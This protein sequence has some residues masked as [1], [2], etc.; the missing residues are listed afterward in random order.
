MVGFVL[1]RGMLGALIGVIIGHWMDR[2]WFGAG[3]A[4]P[5]SA[6]SKAERQSVFSTAVVSLA[7]KLAKCDGP[8]TREEVDAFKRQ[9]SI[10]ASQMASIGALYDRAKASADGYETH[11]RRLAASFAGET[12]LLTEVIEALHQIALADGKLQ[13][14]ERVFLDRVTAIFGLPRR[15]FADQ[16][17]GAAEQD[18]SA[19][20]GVARNAAMSGIKAAWRTLTREHHPDTLMAKGVPPDYI[21]LATRKMAAINAAY[22]RIRSERGES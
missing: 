7:A 22:D 3:G 16:A 13:P 21:D 17:L 20:L 9:F 15:A 5:A 1:G 2:K 6:A 8:V 12:V 14:A 18:P 19:V 4:L 10:P 11:A